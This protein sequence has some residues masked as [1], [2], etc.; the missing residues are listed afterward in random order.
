MVG[1]YTDPNP[2]LSS[3]LAFTSRRDLRLLAGSF[4]VSLLTTDLSNGISTVYLHTHKNHQLGS[5]D[6]K[7]NSL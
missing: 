1:M 6:S 3:N 4:Q 7:A 5:M 2:H